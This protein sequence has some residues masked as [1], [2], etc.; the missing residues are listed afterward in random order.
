VQ[1]WLEAEEFRGGSGRAALSYIGA[2][3]GSAAR[4][5]ERLLEIMGDPLHESR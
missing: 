2:H 3:R 5:A 4:T 1:E